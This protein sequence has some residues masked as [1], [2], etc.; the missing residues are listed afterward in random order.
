M[1]EFLI[2]NKDHWMDSLSVEQVA[3]RIAEK[4]TFEVKYRSRYQRGDIVEVRP[5]GFFTKTLKGDLSKW[6]FRVISIP[7]LPVDST[8]TQGDNVRRCKW[9]FS[10]N[11]GVITIRTTLSA[12]GLRDKAVV[13]NNG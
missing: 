12:A 4:S 13:I 6:P 2:Y 9:A 1:A 5:D 10:V 8:Y 7:G 11:D 3:E